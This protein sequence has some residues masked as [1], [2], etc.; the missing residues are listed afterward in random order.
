MNI[1]PFIQ[2]AFGAIVGGLV[3][4]ATSWFNTMREKRK[5]IQAW[6]EQRYIT[7]GLDPLL[8]YFT[9]MAFGIMRIPDHDTLIL[10]PAVVPVEALTRFEVLLNLSGG[11]EYLGVF[12]AELNICLAPKSDD[13]NVAIEPLFQ[14]CEVLYRLREAIL[15]AIPTRI[16]RKNQRLDITVYR[17]RIVAI[18]DDLLK[19]NHPSKKDSTP[20]DQRV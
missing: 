18:V 9:N 20:S 15:E 17:N 12:I 19:E 4:L 13:K 2:T 8:A 7:E 11:M 6:Y 5:E 10:P 1:S 3:V 16:S 14:L